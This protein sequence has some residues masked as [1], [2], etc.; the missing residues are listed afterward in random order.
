MIDVLCSKATV[1][2]RPAITPDS[3]LHNEIYFRC[4]PNRR[5]SR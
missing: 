4:G 3:L 1:A 5:K 2:A